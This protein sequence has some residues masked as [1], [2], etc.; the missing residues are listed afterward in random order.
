MTALHADPTYIDVYNCRSNHSIF[1]RS[2]HN[3]PDT[4]ELEATATPAIHVDIIAHC[5][6]NADE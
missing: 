3:H 2:P 5:R 6:L 1:E 4:F